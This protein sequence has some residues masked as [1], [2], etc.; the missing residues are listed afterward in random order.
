MYW[1]SMKS[2][3]QW[4]KLGF[5]VLAMSLTANIAWGAKMRAKC[6]LLDKDNQSVQGVDI[7]QAYE[8]AS[9]SKIFTSYW[10]ASTKG[11]DYRFT[12]KLYVTK[13]SE[14]VVN[15]HIEGGWDPYFDRDEM[16]YM[17]AQLNALNVT[18]IQELSFDENF[19]FLIDSRGTVNHTV[20]IG[21]YGLQDPT[22][23]RVLQNVKLF[24]TNPTSGYSAMRVKAKNVA[25][26]ALPAALK[27]KI[28]TVHYVSY[29]D[30]HEQTDVIENSRQMVM[31]SVPLSQIMKEMNRNSNNYIANILFQYLGGAEDFQ[32]FAVKNLKTEPSEV[33][34]VNGSGDRLDLPNGKAAY[35]KA[36]C[37]A[38]VKTIAQF[39]ETLQ[40]QSAQLEQI[41]ALAGEDPSA[42]EESTVSKM[43]GNEATTD[44]LIAKTGTVDPAVTLAGMASTED[45]DVYFGIMY[46]TK[47]TKADWADGRNKIR[48]DVIELFKKFGNKKEIDYDPSQFLAFDHNSHLLEVDSS[49]EASQA[50]EQAAQKSEPKL[51]P[52]PVSDE[53]SYDDMSYGTIHRVRMP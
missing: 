45:G 8:I 50:K 20:P 16:Q 1:S 22:P 47:G 30:F 32:K 44:A 2:Q 21:H 31:R 10:A 14:G 43:Y 15:I 29:D 34:F 11:V 35:N 17:L 23:N 38:I 3:K 26:V 5:C 6:Y 28:G 25:K 13:V 33:Q 39:R 52:P 19:K 12:T 48:K 7:H 4:M 18:K 41:M 49:K 9:V 46:G 53:I 40:S 37:D 36:S 24:A 27:M 51:S 42:R